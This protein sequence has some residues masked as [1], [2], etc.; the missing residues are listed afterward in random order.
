MATLQEWLESC[1]GFD[2]RPCRVAIGKATYVAARYKQ[3]LRTPENS[4]AWNRGE[5]EYTRESIYC[6]GER[7]SAYKRSSKTYFRFIGDSQDWYVCC[8]CPAEV[9]HDPK[10]AAHHPFG[11][12][13]ILAPWDVPDG[14][15]ID[16][17]APRPYTR[18]G[19]SVNYHKAA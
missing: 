16:Y 10:Y 8:Y 14:T 13:F 3:T 15:G 12:S 11:A 19:A 17:Y 18:I 7:P 2:V 6:I 1:G 9:S 5:R 4:P